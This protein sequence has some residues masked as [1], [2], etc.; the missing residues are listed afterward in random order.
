MTNGET[1]TITTIAVGRK[2]L[3]NIFQIR[4]LLHGF[5]LSDLRKEIKGYAM[6][7][8]T[9]SLNLL[10][11]ILECH[12]IRLQA[13]KPEEVNADTNDIKGRIQHVTDL[14]DGFMD[15]IHKAINK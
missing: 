14:L 12:K 15:A 7:P 9:A 8:L 11:I 6:D 13:M 4:D 5:T 3:G 10:S 1:T 2:R